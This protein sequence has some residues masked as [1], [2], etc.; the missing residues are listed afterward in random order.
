MPSSSFRPISRTT[1]ANIATFPT[2]GAPAEH[3]D[4][5]CCSRFTEVG[6]AV[7]GDAGRTS[8]VGCGG[9]GAHGSARAGFRC[10]QRLRPVHQRSTTPSSSN[11]WRRA[12]EPI[13][14]QQATRRP[15]AASAHHANAHSPE[16]TER[17]TLLSQRLGKMAGRWALRLCS[18]A[19]RLAG[20]YSAPQCN[21]LPAARE[22][23]IQSAPLRRLH[24]I[25][26]TCHG[27]VA[28]GRSPPRFT[29]PS[30]QRP[31]SDHATPVRKRLA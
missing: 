1:L 9:S 13:P 28:L 17:V 11:W 20:D 14:G 5:R 23:A 3:G 25:L 15:P 8:R 27:R 24:E 21:W 22:S 30:R 6:E 16:E 31:G 4:G 10:G 19:G 7:R 26:L 29:A 18:G 2:A 12:S